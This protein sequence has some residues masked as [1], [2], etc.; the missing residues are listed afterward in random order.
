MSQRKAEK[1]KN[2][3]G[4]KTL[5]LRKETLKDLTAD[6]GRANRVRGGVVTRKAGEQQHWTEA[7]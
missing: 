5:T 1:I 2:M 4:R 3:P 6:V 7:C